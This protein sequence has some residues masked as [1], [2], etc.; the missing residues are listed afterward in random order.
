[1]KNKKGKKNGKMTKAGKEILSA[2]M[3]IKEALDNGVPL[4]ERFNLR[5]YPASTRAKSFS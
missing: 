2:L 3:E 5:V 1:M 4:G